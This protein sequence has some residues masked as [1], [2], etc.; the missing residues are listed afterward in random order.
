MAFR[1]GKTAQPAS[2]RVKPG[3]RAG[4]MVIYVHGLECE[5]RGY[6]SATKSHKAV[7]GLA[8]CGANLLRGASRPTPPTANSPMQARFSRAGEVLGAPGATDV[9]DVRLR[10]LCAGQRLG[11]LVNRAQ[12]FIGPVPMQERRSLNHAQT[13]M[14][15]AR[16]GL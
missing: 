16:R 4:S 13:L 11:A 7:A 8:R 1:G 6:L 3:P 10:S 14:R 12:C 15:T 5:Q 2:Q 9:H